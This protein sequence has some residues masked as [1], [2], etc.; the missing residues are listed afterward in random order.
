MW[1]PVFPLNGINKDL[2]FVTSQLSV[3]NKI[4]PSKIAQFET[5]IISFRRS[6]RGNPCQ[7]Q[8]SQGWGWGEEMLR[9]TKRHCSQIQNKATFLLRGT[10]RL[11][12]LHLLPEGGHF[13]FILSYLGLHLIPLLL[14]GSQLIHQLLVG[15]LRLGRSCGLLRLLPGWCGLHLIQLLLRGLRLLLVLAA[16]LLQ[17]LIHT[18]CGHDTTTS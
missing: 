16:D 12:L 6:T 15:L 8:I 3:T 14:G 9:K 18:H 11:Y 2:T 1:R 5:V 7:R 10:H 13:R 4:P 17:L